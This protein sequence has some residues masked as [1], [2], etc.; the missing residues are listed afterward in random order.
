MYKDIEA[1]RRRVNAIMFLLGLGSYTKIYAFGLISF[2]EIGMFLFAPLYFF[3]N[4]RYLASCGMMPII[5]LIFAMMAGNLIGKIV[6]NVSYVVFV[7]DIATYYSAFAAVVVFFAM[8]TRSPKSLGYF[9]VGAFLSSIISIFA[10][11]PQLNFDGGGFGQMTTLSVEETVQGVMFWFSKV[12]QAVKLPIAAAY[13]NIPILYPIVALPAAAMFSIMSSVSGRSAAAGCLA[14]WFFIC[15]CRKSSIRMVRMGRH[16]VLF[17][18][19]AVLGVYAV[20]TAYS[21]SASRG[22]LGGAAQDKYY[23]QTKG[24]DSL[25][26]VLIGGRTEFFVALRACF[27]RPIIGI[28]P[29]AIDKN[30]YYRD[31]LLKYGDDKDLEYYQYTVQKLGVALIPQHSCITM[32]WARAGIFGLIFWLY[33][34]WIFI[35][36][37]VKDMGVVPHWFGYLALVIPEFVFTIFF[38][39]YTNRIEPM[40]AVACVLV[41]RAIAKGSVLL[42]EDVIREICKH[43]K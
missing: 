21:Y 15:I 28:G 25:L 43:D 19:I 6:N 39:P 30:G 34:L 14:S 29:Y 22:I 8:L 27:D 3:K 9:V 36:Y 41:S 11:N 40:L 18:V 42:P 12:N 2:S 13:L 38:N 35:R 20:K 33:V 5:M 24:N 4:R 10:F 1:N 23:A 16:V 17:G 37:F 26:S 31:L 32:F 7:K